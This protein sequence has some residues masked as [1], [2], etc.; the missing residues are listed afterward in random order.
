RKP[1]A[2]TLMPLLDPLMK[3]ILSYDFLGKIIKTY[4]HPEGVKVT[5]RI[6]PLVADLPAVREAG[7]FL[8][9]SAKMFC[10]F[11][12][13]TN[14]EKARL[15]YWLWPMRISATVLKQAKSWLK[16]P[17]KEKR[18]NLERRTGVR[19][20]SLHLLKYRDPVND[21]FSSG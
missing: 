5:A 8:S 14:D 15:D 4:S 17:T 9:Y 3:T 7:R 20:C 16:Q 1:S 13:L 21:T 18:V 2:T 19:F 12:L 10:S 6:I 11:C